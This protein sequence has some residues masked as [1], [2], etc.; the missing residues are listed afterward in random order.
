[1]I[2]NTASPLARRTALVTGGSRGIG[3]ATAINLAQ[4]GAHVVLTYRSS[5][6]E[7]ELIAKT[8]H[9]AAGSAAMLHADLDG[10][11]GVD[12]LLTELARTTGDIDIV[13]DNAVAPLPRAGILDLETQQILDKVTADLAILHRLIQ[14]LTP[15]MQQRGFGRIIAITSGHAIGPTA[16]GMTAYGVTKAAIE[17]L[18]RYAAAEVGHSGVT[19]NAVRPGLVNTDTSNDV[20][21][22]VREAMART[23]PARRIATADDIA[24]IVALVAQ[25]ISGWV[26]GVAIPATGGLNY[27]IDWARIYP[28]AYA[29]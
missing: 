3:A 9:A 28:E 27:P 19:V 22:T 16:P 29:Q 25:P 23:I 24:K 8:C 20:P 6:S 26:N 17:A 15:G 21:A 18:V 11:Q 12:T 7:A 14:A 4:L 1:M 10:R 5:R 2:D 13:V